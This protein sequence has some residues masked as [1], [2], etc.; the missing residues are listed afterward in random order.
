METG[1]GNVRERM[2]GALR[3]AMKARDRVAVPALRAG[4]AAIDNAEAVGAGQGTRVVASHP[5]LAGTRVGLGAG[6][7]ARRVLTDADIE[8]IVRAEAGELRSAAEGYRRAGQAEE[9][10]RLLGQAAVLTGCLGAADRD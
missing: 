10:E 1:A 8:A 2:R 3:A 7:V 4:L 6:E 5:E 9:A